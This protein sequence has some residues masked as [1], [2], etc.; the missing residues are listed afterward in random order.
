MILKLVISEKQTCNLTVLDGAKNLSN[1]L[2]IIEIIKSTAL[3]SKRTHSS[4]A[5]FSIIIHF[6]ENY[7]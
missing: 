3:I 7:Q 4:V 2:Y 1:Q 5:V 6:I